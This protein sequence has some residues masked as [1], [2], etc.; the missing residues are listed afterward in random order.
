MI[1]DQLT[2]DR[3][4]VLQID[5]EWSRALETRDVATLNRIL[6]DEFVITTSSGR[7][8][9]KAEYITY[10]NS[11]RGV[12]K[13]VQAGKD[14]HVEGNAAIVCALTRFSRSDADLRV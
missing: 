8:L 13:P 10:V 14:V 3:E 9:N 2:S 12:F 5:E 7:R 1:T 4:R 6:A 11:G